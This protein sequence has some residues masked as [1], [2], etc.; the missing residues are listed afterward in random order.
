[1]DA[2]G[3][4]DAQNA[5]TAPWKTAQ[6]AVS[7]SAHTHPR[8]QEEERTERK[9]ST[10]PTHKISDTPANLVDELEI[11]PNRLA[12]GQSYHLPPHQ[13]GEL[14]RLEILKTSH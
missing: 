7:H 2:A 5:S 3:A 13:N 10:R 4:V 11:A 8:F 12:I 6:T 14:V 1:M 9:T